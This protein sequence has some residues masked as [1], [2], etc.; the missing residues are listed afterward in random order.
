MKI[1]IKRGRI[2][3]LFIKSD[4]CVVQSTI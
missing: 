1:D 2:C 3:Q 4:S